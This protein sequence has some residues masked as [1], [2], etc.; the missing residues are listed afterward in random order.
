MSLSSYSNAAFGIGSELRDML[1]SDDFSHMRAQLSLA[2]AEQLVNARY[3]NADLV[4]AIAIAQPKPRQK[5]LEKL[6]PEKRFWMIAAAAQMAFESS[7]VLA[8]ADLSLAPG[9]SY[10]EMIGRV[11][12]VL[13]AQHTSPDAEW[14]FPGPSPFRY[15]D[16]A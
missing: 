3:E 14:P 7:A 8:E 12:D 11:Q 10:R 16:E 1:L 9:G 6:P 4:R 15:P 5:L 13:L 2:S